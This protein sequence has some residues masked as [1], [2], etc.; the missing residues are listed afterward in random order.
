MAALTPRKKLNAYGYII[1]QAG[2]KK[3]GRTSGSS[4]R[5]G[6]KRA[7]AI[8]QI[9]KKLV[10]ATEET[11]E[12]FGLN[13]KNRDHKLWLLHWLAFAIYGKGPGQPKKWTAKSHQTL[14]DDIAELRRRMPNAKEGKLCYE[15]CKGK[16]KLDRYKGKQP[17]TLR[18]QLQNAKGLQK[19]DLDEEARARSLKKLI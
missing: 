7:A 10:R 11:L 2:P 3:T 9:A 18:R 13:G 19:Q 12:R 8:D 15:L 5:R 16:L 17:E 4:K 1:K 14:L 6:D